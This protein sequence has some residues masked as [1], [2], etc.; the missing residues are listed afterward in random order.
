MPKHAVPKIAFLIAFNLL[1]AITLAWFHKPIVLAAG[2]LVAIPAYAGSVFTSFFVDG[3]LEM[4]TW[5]TKSDPFWGS[6]HLE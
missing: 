4:I 1:I 2:Q 5:S 3:Q 6:V